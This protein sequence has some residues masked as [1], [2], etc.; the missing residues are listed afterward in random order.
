MI[1]IFAS[2]FK[3]TPSLILVI[4]ASVATFV[5]YVW[6]MQTPYFEAIYA[7]CIANFWLM[8]SIVIILKIVGIIWPPL[9]GGLAAIAIIPITGFW[10]AY[11]TD[12]VGSIIGCTIVYFIG[13]KYGKPFLVKVLG[14]D[15]ANQVEKFRVRK[16]RE[17]EAFFAF[18]AL[19]GGVFV[20]AVSYGA[21]I[22]GMKYRRF[23]LATVVTHLMVSLP[24]F[25]MY[26]VLYESQSVYVMTLSTLITLPILWKLRGRYFDEAFS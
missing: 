23:F 7:W 20:E 22:T 5:L 19:A 24:I 14:E 17:Y 18:R 13:K 9:P 2:K 21:G 12:L 1:D 4:L 26:S 10:I 3:I 8:I 25:F 11:L 6:F 16:D 15:F